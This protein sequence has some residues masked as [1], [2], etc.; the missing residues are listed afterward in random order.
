MCAFT[1]NI[2]VGA[3]FT[4][5]DLNLHPAGTV[6]KPKQWLQRLPSVPSRHFEAVLG[7]FT[8]NLLPNCPVRHAC[9]AF[10]ALSV[11]PELCVPGLWLPEQ[12]H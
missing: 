8:T 2:D 5:P 1:F 10:D 12:S 11:K 6:A 4:T 7:I 3:G 9:R